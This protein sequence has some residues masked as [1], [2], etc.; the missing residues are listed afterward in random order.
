MSAPSTDLISFLAPYPTAIQNTAL[1]IRALILATTPN[2]YELIWDNYN[3]VAVAYSTSEQL[4]DAYCHFAV[5]GKHV[6]LG[7]NRGVALV[8]KKK[9]FRGKGKLIR[10]INIIDLADQDTNYL[11][12]LI[13]DARLL[14]EERNP[15]YVAGSLE[16][17][18]VV[19]SI[20]E[21]KRRPS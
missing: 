9:L 3:A 17:K 20:S 19:K 18:S 21:K 15:K 7:F 8:D 6:N 16:F 2:V 12:N 14:S 1:K 10:H 4:K 13:M 5:Y 11:Q